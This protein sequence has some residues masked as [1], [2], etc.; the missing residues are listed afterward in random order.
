MPMSLLLQEYLLFIGKISDM[1]VDYCP[2]FRVSRKVVLSYRE[3]KKLSA[4]TFELVR[5]LVSHFYFINEKSVSSAV[6]CAWS[7]G[8]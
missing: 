3:L 4:F 7:D 2:C 8:N 5:L 6:V 1:V